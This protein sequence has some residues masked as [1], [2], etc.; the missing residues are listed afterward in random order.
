[1]KRL[2]SITVRPRLKNEILNLK[3]VRWFNLSIIGSFC[4]IL[5]TSCAS[6]YFC[7]LNSRGITPSNKTYY[8]NP[9]DSTATNY[10]EFQEYANILKARLNEI[11]YLENTPQEAFLRIQ[12]QY[13]M[14]DPY[15]SQVDTKA[16][17]YSSSSYTYTTGKQ[18]ETPKYKIPILVTIRAFDNKTNTPI[19]E[20]T[21]K[22]ELDRETQIQ[23][24]MPWL[25]SSIK[26]YIGKNS[27][28][29]QTVK[30]Y[31]TKETREKYN[32]IW[33]Y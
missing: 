9:I 19:W 33:P 16:K 4:L 13:D 25:L 23:T 15:L 27:N 6:G 31:N 8:I 20:V 7:T 2:L 21:A 22:D 5:T 17:V 28:G 3:F 30:I 32:L 14:K 10:L 24:V 11:G 18:T 1:M 12:L 29:E 26:N